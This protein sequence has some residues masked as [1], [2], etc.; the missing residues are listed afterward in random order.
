LKKSLGN[1]GVEPRYDDGKPSPNGAEATFYRSNIWL[2]RTLD[3][4]FLVRSFLYA[5]VSPW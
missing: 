4:D 3:L 5:S 1:E 2:R